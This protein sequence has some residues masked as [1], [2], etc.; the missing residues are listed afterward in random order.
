MD[1][2]GFEGKFL[3]KP[4]EV[5]GEKERKNMEREIHELFSCAPEGVVQG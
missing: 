2:F 3:R 1:L 5:L 4:L